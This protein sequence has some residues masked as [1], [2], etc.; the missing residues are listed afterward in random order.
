MR[1]GR[2]V[3]TLTLTD[4]EREML[5]GW[6]Q[7]GAG[8]GPACPNSSGMRQ[9]QDEHGCGCGDESVASDGWEVEVSIL[10]ASSGWTGGRAEVRQAPYR[11]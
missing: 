1:L 7:D 2:P 10:G 5:G 11:H 6:T 9:R 3:P 8:I 4:E